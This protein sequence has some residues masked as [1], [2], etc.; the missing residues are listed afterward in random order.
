MIENAFDVLTSALAAAE[1]AT[2]NGLRGFIIDHPEGSRGAFLVLLPDVVDE[3]WN[4]YNVGKLFGVAN[5]VFVPVNAMLKGYSTFVTTRDMSAYKA[6]SLRVGSPVV[7][8]NTA[9][10]PDGFTRFWSADAIPEGAVLAGG[11]VLVTGDENHMAM[12]YDAFKLMNK[13]PHVKMQRYDATSFVVYRMFK[14][15]LA[16]LSV[17]AS[18]RKIAPAQR[19]SEEAVNIVLRCINKIQVKRVLPAFKILD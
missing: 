15:S 19:A 9:E 18:G 7:C 17:E 13:V 5:N 6:P 11:G 8:G 4:G 14:P 1:P 10:K 16:K 3:E 12:F 2:N